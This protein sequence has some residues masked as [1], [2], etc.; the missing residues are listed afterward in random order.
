VEW[1]GEGCLI[2]ELV[3]GPSWDGKVYSVA[4]KLTALA[5]QISDLVRLA[6]SKSREGHK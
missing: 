3:K 2:S 6:D 4:D 1:S 5:Y